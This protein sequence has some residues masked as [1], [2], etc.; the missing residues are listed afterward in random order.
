[1]DDIDRLKYKFKYF[2]NER[3]LW[4]AK[5]KMDYQC[6][7]RYN[8]MIN[9]NSVVMDKFSRG[10]TCMEYWT[11]FNGEPKT[12]DFLQNNFLKDITTY[13]PKITQYRRIK[14]N[15]KRNHWQTYSS[16]VRKQETFFDKSSSVCHLRRDLVD[17]MGLGNAFIISDYE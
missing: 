13:V 1:M 15:K 14:L 6:K 8:V 10:L 4:V 7:N 5:Q 2:R 9:M 17:E 11:V 3:F 12:L 16:Y